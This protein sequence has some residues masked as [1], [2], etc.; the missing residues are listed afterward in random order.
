MS[1]VLDSWGCKLIFLPNR[2]ISLTTTFP[3]SDNP[4]LSAGIS[5]DSLGDES[6]LECMH[7]IFQNQSQDNISQDVKVVNQFSWIKHWLVAKM[8][9]QYPFPVNHH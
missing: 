6:A 3:N 8:L 9:L 5:P 4:L 1:V 7:K 2:F